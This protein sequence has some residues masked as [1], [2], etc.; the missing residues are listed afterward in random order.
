MSP[1]YLEYSAFYE[2]YIF[3]SD[4]KLIINVDHTIKFFKNA[5]SLRKSGSDIC[6]NID[7]VI[8]T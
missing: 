7:L 6:T 1:K 2:S 4:F 3:G 5:F 8:L